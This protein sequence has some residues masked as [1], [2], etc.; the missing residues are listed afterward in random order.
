M[1][2]M[3][4]NI[5]EWCQDLHRPYPGAPPFPDIDIRGA[6][7]C[8]FGDVPELLRSGRRAAQYPIIDGGN[9]GFRVARTLR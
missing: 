8:A 1:F 6:R 4:G 3:L 7:G 5:M 2:D 9:G